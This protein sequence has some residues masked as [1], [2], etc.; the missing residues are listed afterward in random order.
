M[1][2]QKIGADFEDD[3]A[4]IL[5]DLGFWVRVDKRKTQSCD[6]FAARNNIMYL[7]EAKTCKKNYFNFNRI[8]DNQVLSRRKF[9]K[10]GNDEAWIVYLIGK[11]IY[12]SEDF[13]KHPMDLGIKFDVWLERR[14]I[15]ASNYRK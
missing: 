12:L 10:C 3:F 5:A 15:D 7:F 1:N 9:K 6:I 2:N 13:V 8:R 14:G 4:K 11:E